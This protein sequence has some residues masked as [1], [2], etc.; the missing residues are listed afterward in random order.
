MTK[1]DL[2]KLIETEVAKIATETM[3]EPEK[4]LPEMRALKQVFN[5]ALKDEGEID[6]FLFR[7]GMKD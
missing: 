5:P 2:L 6:E 4:T 1:K 7:A 3:R